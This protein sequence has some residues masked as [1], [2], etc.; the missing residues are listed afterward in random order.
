MAQCSRVHGSSNL[1]QTLLAN[2]LVDVVLDIPVTLG[3]E[4]LF[5]EGTIPR[6]RLA[7]STISPGGV[8][9]A[10]YNRDEVGSGRSLGIVC[11]PHPPTPRW[12][13]GR[14]P[15][16]RLTMGAGGSAQDGPDAGC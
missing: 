11:Q 8:I 13:P 3:K 7:V 15:D 16:L 1:L 10:S 14:A 9:I 6:F 12:S 4:S 2:D 5:G